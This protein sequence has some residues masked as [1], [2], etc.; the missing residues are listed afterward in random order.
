MTKCNLDKGKLKLKG[1]M[2][3][4]SEWNYILFLCHPVY[5]IV[6]IIKIFCRIKWF[7]FIFIK[8]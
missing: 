3:Y 6:I 8:D 5:V 2:K 4:F 1:Q 7:Y